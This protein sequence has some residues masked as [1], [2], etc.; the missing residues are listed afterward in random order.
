ML[1]LFADFSWDNDVRLRSRPHLQSAL[2]I[3]IPQNDCSTGERVRVL[4]RGAVSPAGRS[5]PM[6]D[7]PP[8]PTADLRLASVA[9][10][11][12]IPLAS[13]SKVVLTVGSNQWQAPDSEVVGSK[14]DD[15]ATLEVVDNSRK[16]PDDQLCVLER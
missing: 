2:G 4:Q 16:V 5:M 11:S 15:G 13:S 9:S 7:V 14:R 12:R 6:P 8:M 10:V 3:V 1:A